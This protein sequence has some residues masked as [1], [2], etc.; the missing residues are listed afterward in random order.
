M[1]AVTISSLNLAQKRLAKGSTDVGQLLEG[2]LDGAQRAA[3]LTSRLLAFSRQQPLEP[4]SLNLNRIVGG[5]SDMISRTKTLPPSR[6]LARVV[7]QPSVRTC[8]PMTKLPMM[9]ER[10]EISIIGP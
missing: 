7:T 2:A 3:T 10:R 4:K 1:L 5:M 6:P 9:S 8:Q